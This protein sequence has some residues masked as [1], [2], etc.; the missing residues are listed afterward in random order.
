MM[1][2][3]IRVLYYFG[4]YLGIKFGLSGQHLKPDDLILEALEFNRLTSGTFADLLEETASISEFFG[5]IGQMAD[6]LGHGLNWDEIK[7][8]QDSRAVIVNKGIGRAV[9]SKAWDTTKEFWANV[10][11][12]LSDSD[13]DS[14]W[15]DDLIDPILRIPT[16]LEQSLGE[17]V[18]QKREKHPTTAPNTTYCVLPTPNV[19]EHPKIKEL[20]EINL[21]MRALVS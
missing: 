13:Q 6:Q 10:V 3:T 15:H 5:V 21:R 18:F 14:E 7:T 20:K 8:L 11:I 17:D 12:E 1:T 2:N 4:C 16:E 19:K 9:Q